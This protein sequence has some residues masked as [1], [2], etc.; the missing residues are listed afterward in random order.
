ML[1]PN[2]L[3]SLLLED[4][5]TFS[6]QRREPKHNTYTRGLSCV[7]V[8]LAGH[9]EALVISCAWGGGGGADVVW[10]PTGTEDDSCATVRAW[11]VLHA[12]FLDLISPLRIY[13]SILPSSL[14][15]RPS[16]IT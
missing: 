2:P 15:Q 9:I 8:V 4:A 6:Q 11:R 14:T 12:A 3:I 13:H 5:I 7:T 10:G 1:N 16:P